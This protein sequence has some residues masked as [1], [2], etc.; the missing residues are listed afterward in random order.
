MSVTET[1]PLKLNHKQVERIV[2]DSLRRFAP[3]LHLVHKVHPDEYAGTGLPDF[4]GHI[5]GCYIG[6]EIKVHPDRPKPAQS[7]WCEKINRSGA[8]SIVLC[9]HKGEFRFWLPSCG[10]FTYRNFD[11]WPELPHRRFPVK[12]GG[13]AVVLNF[14]PLIPLL[15]AKLLLALASAQAIVRGS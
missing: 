7:G 15:N 9:H 4:E 6:I 8:M 14:L 11:R 12:G 5:F 1:A 2:Q 13:E 3:D 10:E